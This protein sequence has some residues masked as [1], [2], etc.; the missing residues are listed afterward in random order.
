M[1]RRLSLRV[2]LYCVFFFFS[3]KNVRQIHNP[4]WDI[5][6]AQSRQ[7][8]IPLTLSHLGMRFPHPLIP[9]FVSQYRID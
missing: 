2:T 9:T 3:L 8:G 7:K 1:R 5:P 4:H 6:Y